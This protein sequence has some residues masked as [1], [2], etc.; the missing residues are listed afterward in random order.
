L[1]DCRIGD[2]RDFSRFLQL[3]AAQV[4]QTLDMSLYARDIGVSVTTI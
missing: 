4:A 1:H 3:L 2:L